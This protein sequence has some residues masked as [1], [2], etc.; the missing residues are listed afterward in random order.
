MEFIQYI[1]ENFNFNEII[2]LL[3]IGIMYGI[4]YILIT[5]H[6]KNK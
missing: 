1:F 4:I 6:K 2:F 3:E 5:L